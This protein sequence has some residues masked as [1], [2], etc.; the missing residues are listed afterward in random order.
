MYRTTRRIVSAS[1]VYITC[2][3]STVS[4]F[5]ADKT[6]IRPRSG[7]TDLHSSFAGCNNLDQVLSIL[8]SRH[9]CLCSLILSWVSRAQNWRSSGLLPLGA[10]LD[11]RSNIDLR[12]SNSDRMIDDSPGTG[13]YSAEN[14]V[15]IS[16]GMRLRLFIS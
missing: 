2:E 15:S 1:S 7:Q 9:Q 14:H 8:A 5:G 4:R 13:S 11:P 16:P 3:L 6:M 10:L 12:R